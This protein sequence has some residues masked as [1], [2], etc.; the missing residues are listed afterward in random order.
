[1]YIRSQK[2]VQAAPG[3]PPSKAEALFVCQVA[4][5]SA[6]RRSGQL[7]CLAHWRSLPINLQE[8]VTRT[9]NA[10]RQGHSDYHAYKAARREALQHFE[11]K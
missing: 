2:S 8:S 11:R 7:M 3:A 6:E 4:G 9:W 5:C 1:M 10:W